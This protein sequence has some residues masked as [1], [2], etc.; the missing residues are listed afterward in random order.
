M[1]NENEELEENFKMEDDDELDS[2]YEETDDFNLDEE[3]PDK[4]H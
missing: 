1:D 4:D 2:P 3:D